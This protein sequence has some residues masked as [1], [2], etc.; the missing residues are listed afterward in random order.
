MRTTKAKKK[1]KL[2]VILLNNFVEV[3]I[4][5]QMKIFSILPNC[6]KTNISLTL[7]LLT[8]YNTVVLIAGEN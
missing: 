8:N 1:E 6:T 7:F 4:K 2:E 3:E 5:I